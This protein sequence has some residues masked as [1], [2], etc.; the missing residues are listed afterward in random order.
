MQLKTERIILGMKHWNHMLN[1]TMII[2]LHH[3]SY[4]QFFEYE[5]SFTSSLIIDPS[6]ASQRNL[7]S[8][9]DSDGENPPDIPQLHNSSFIIDD[10]EDFKD[11]SL[12]TFCGSCKNHVMTMVT[13]KAGK[14][15]LLFAVA[16]C[17]LGCFG[18]C[19]LV[20]FLW[21]RFQD[22]EHLCPNCQLKL[23]KYRRKTKNICCKV[24]TILRLCLSLTSMANR[25]VTRKRLYLTSLLKSLFL[26]SKELP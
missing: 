4:F 10:R 7:A 12:Y 20:P 9:A 24:R 22:V 11:E 8:K 2:S 13:Y 3:Y 18:G 15:T 19:C 17:F 14:L 16:L 5:K 21:K 1:F 26:N 6:V 23:G 25:Y